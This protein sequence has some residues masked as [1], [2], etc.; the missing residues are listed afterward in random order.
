MAKTT[1]VVDD[2]VLLKAKQV[3]EGNLS[4]FIEKLLRKE[5]LNERES[6]FGAFSKSKLSAKGLR[7]KTD[8]VDAW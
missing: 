3:S 8:R 2:F 5:V 7:E 6:M 1:I 4:K